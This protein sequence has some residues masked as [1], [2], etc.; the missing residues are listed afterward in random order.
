[1]SFV[2]LP[3]CTRGDLKVHSLIFCH[4]GAAQQAVNARLAY[5]DLTML[6]YQTCWQTGAY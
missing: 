2:S 3:L 4:L 5:Y 6:L 1:M